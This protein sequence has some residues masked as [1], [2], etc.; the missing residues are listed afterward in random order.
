MEVAHQLFA[1]VYATATVIGVVLG[2]IVWRHREKAGATPLAIYLVNVVFWP[3]ALFVATAV[4]SYTVAAFMHRFLFVGVGICVVALVV[5][6]LE[7]TGREHLVTRR[8]LGLLSIEPILVVILAFTNPDNVFFATF[9]PDPSLPAG[10]AVEWGIAFE[11]HTIYSYALLLSVTLL[12]VELLYSSKAL[13]RGQATALFF[14]TTIPWATNAIHV[15]GPVQ[16]DTTAIGFLVGGA[17]YS[18]AIVRYRLIDVVPIARDRVLATVSDGI[19]VV[20]REDRLIDVNPAGRQLVSVTDD[21]IGRTIDSLFFDFPELLEHYESFVERPTESEREMAVD[22]RFYHVRVTPIDD[23]CERHVG[24]LF[25]IRDVTERKHREHRLRRQNDRLEGF[26]DMVSHD[27]RS[28][29][30]VA[31]E[32]L[33]LAQETGDLRYL[34]RVGESHERMKTIIED[35]LEL[36]RD[37]THVSEVEPIELESVARQAWGNA[38]VGTAAFEVH[39]SAT[40]HADVDRT[41]RLLENLFRNAVEHGSTSPA[42]QAHQDAVEHGHPGT[43]FV[44]DGDL[45]HDLTCRRPDGE[46]VTDTY[47]GPGRDRVGHG[48][49]DVGSSAGVTI[50]VGIIE[51]DTGTGTGFYVE[52]DGPGISEAE[53]DQIFDYGYST[54][55]DG[56]ELELSIVRRIATAHGW[57]VT[58]CTGE[59]GGAR[60]EFEG[61]RTV[62]NVGS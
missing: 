46:A 27:L 61:V 36:A 43:Q 8:T 33:E 23:G 34:S 48:S 55:G 35:V 59:M 6:A 18:I 14:G 54:G 49:D 58:V 60:F 57:S 51:D 42:S 32:Y 30:N 26:A 53:R 20:D 21:P 62:T 38:D 10:V 7:Y 17:L 47:S 11:L 1:I 19:F 39:T 41:L 50:R 28:P 5:F 4:D 45:E 56:A 15:V 9:E 44:A 3:G 31:D 29:L 25:V 22:D 40:I 16:A 13:Y 52:D 37:G 2:A 24:W 12:I